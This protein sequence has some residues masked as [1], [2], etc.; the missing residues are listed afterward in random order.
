MS[1][2]RRPRAPFVIS[3]AAVCRKICGAH[4]F[5]DTAHEMLIGELI[6]KAKADH[7]ELKVTLA[8]LKA[9]SPARPD[10]KLT[11]SDCEVIAMIEERESC[12]DQAGAERLLGE[13]KAMV[14]LVTGD[15]DYVREHESRTGR[16]MVGSVRPVSWPRSHSAVALTHSP[17]IVR[18][19]SRPRGAGRPRARALARASSR[20]GDSGDDDGESEPPRRRRLRLLSSDRE[21]R[22]GPAAQ[23]CFHDPGRGGGRRKESDDDD[24]SQACP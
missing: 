2:E 5:L 9:L 12:G 4:V 17:A 21:P 6:A 20:G 23:C 22:A 10:G 8:G 7:P 14:A 11:D 24:V 1:F 16:Q 15:M 3:P 18:R 19:G 13:L